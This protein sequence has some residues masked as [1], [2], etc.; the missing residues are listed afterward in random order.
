MA[1]NQALE[2]RLEA[3][4]TQERILQAE[5]K[6]LEVQL[7]QTGAAGPAAAGS[8]IVQNTLTKGLAINSLAGKSVMEILRFQG[9]G[10]QEKS[11]SVPAVEP[12][13]SSGPEKTRTNVVAA[14]SS[15][16]TTP[17]PEIAMPTKA[18]ASVSS[19]GATVTNVSHTPKPSVV[20]TPAATAKKSVQSTQDHGRGD[21]S[22]PAPLSGTVIYKGKGQAT[23]NAPGAILLTAPMKAE[24]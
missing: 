2:K 8:A 21:P 1:E 18:A 9:D 19:K 13:H 16:E 22:H 3:L 5:N 23:V 4:A 10:N 20:K 12:E 15:M 24:C 17:L 6:T 14:V 11:S 7:N